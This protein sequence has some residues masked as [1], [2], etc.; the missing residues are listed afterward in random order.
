M[1]THG[2]RPL[3]AAKAAPPNNTQPRCPHAAALARV[4]PS[5]RSTF[6][7]G[8]MAYDPANGPLVNNGAQSYEPHAW[9]C[10]YGWA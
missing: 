4:P 8:V 9:G 10:L 6:N 1:H 3:P 5:E 7:Y 2:F